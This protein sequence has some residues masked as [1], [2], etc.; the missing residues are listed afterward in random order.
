MRGKY[1]KFNP[2]R[3]CHSH[4]YGGSSASLQTQRRDF[5]YA[6]THFFSSFLFFPFFFLAPISFFFLLFFFFPKSHIPSSSRPHHK[7]CYKKS[8]GQGGC[9]ERFLLRRGGCQLRQEMLRGPDPAPA[10]LGGDTPAPQTLCS[11]SGSPLFSISSSSPSWVV[12]FSWSVGASKI[13]EFHPKNT[14]GGV[15]SYFLAVIKP[16]WVSH[17]GSRGHPGTEWCPP[18]CLWSP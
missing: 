11:P 16:P 3:A 1:S 6:P 4:S 9:G 2:P 8:P 17:G 7:L 15:A 18:G 10:P 13:V 12:S 5:T 14:T